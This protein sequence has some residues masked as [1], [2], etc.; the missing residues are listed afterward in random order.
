MKKKLLA[1]V[2][3]GALAISLAACS[4]TRGGDDPSGAAASTD[5]NV[6]I[7]M[8]TRS[9]ERWIGERPNTK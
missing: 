7:A 5:C 2:A 6:G 9:L 1:A 3:V 8:P 4:S